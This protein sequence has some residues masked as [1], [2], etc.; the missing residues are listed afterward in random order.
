MSRR[1]LVNPE[2]VETKLVTTEDFPLLDRAYAEIYLPAFPK[3]DQRESLADLKRYIQH[4][5]STEE[6]QILITQHTSPAGYQRPLS[7]ATA[8][9]L[10]D[11]EITI[12]FF[13]YAAVHPSYQGQGLWGSITKARTRFVEEKAKELNTTLAAVFTETEKPH[14]FGRMKFS[15]DP[16]DTYYHLDFDYVQLPVRDDA[17]PVHNLA[18][19]ARFAPEERE[20]YLHGG[21]PSELMLRCL[22]L[23]FNSFEVEYDYRE[24]P[25][26]KQMEEEIKQSNI[27][28]LKLG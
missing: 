23:Y 12:A 7:I 10:S 18:L 22:H 13:E 26:Y 3:A 6:Y 4:N 25:G 8:N 27:R 20:Q 2:T 21:I 14:L 9:Y 16:N 24:H 28:L 5:S 15:D 19:L 11:S 17:Q 1:M